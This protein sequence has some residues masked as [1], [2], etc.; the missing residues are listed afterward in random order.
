MKITVAVENSV[1]FPFNPGIRPGILGEHGL[2]FVVE[3]DGEKWLYD[4]GRGIALLPNLRTLQI[5][6]DEIR[7]VILSH[8]HLDHFGAL[9]DFLKVRSTP[10]DVYMH[11][12][13][14]ARRY[15]R[16]GDSYRFVGL[17]WSEEELTSA[18]A[19]L[20]QNEEPLCLAPGL[21]L[22]G[23]VERKNNFE[24]V[25][26]KFFIDGENGEKCHDTIVDD[27]ALLIETRKGVIVLTGCAHA[28]ICNIL[29]TAKVILP[30]K[31]VRAVL[32]GLH[33]EGATTARLQATADYL[34]AQH[35]DMLAVGHCTGFGA[36]CLLNGRMPGIFTPINAGMVIT[37]D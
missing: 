1:A 3:L 12:A 29:E 37:L 5:E 30:H 20:H 25:E 8:A 27:Q 16:I 9:M 19:I 17:P 10:V 32:G 34:Q 22:T 4:T 26:K 18:G 23:G 31:H 13:A 21:W 2:S 6:P 33:L 14:F 24:S 11:Q 36:C 35:L 15:T 28:G 7:G